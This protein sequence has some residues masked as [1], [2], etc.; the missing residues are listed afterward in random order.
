MDNSIKKLLIGLIIATITLIIIFNLKSYVFV[1]IDTSTI[2]IPKVI[3]I[4]GKRIDDQEIITIIYEVIAEGR[5]RET[6][7]RKQFRFYG[8]FFDIKTDYEDEKH[9]KVEINDIKNGHI[10]RFNI[11]EDDIIAF[12]YYIDD[13][14]NAKDFRVVTIRSK[15]IYEYIKSIIYNN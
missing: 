13:S 1:H 5:V 7:M 11:F 15:G 4:D 9:S 8:N 3:S 14:L 6:R 2:L 12:E 10:H